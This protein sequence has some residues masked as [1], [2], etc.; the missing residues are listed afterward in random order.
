MLPL[1]TAEHT[2]SNPRRSRY[3]RYGYSGKALAIRCETLVFGFG[4]M[5]ILCCVLYAVS[6]LRIVGPMRSEFVIYAVL[7][8]TALF[9]ALSGIL[10]TLCC[11]NR[12][13]H[14]CSAVLQAVYAVMAMFVLVA[15]IRKILAVLVDNND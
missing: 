9:L 15:W 5:V 3:N 1:H 7:Q 8:L 13:F 10:L 2:P 6:K 11:G 4:A 12:C 14:G